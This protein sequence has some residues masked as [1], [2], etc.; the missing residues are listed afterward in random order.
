MV[1][2]KEEEKELL[3]RAF[4]CYYEKCVWN[5]M[6]NENNDKASTEDYNIRQL[7]DK[8]GIKHM[9]PDEIRRGW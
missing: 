8:L 9:F 6:R 3:I 4:T 1:E 2:L 7:A 5:D